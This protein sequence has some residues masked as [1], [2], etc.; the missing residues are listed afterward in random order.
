MVVTERHILTLAAKYKNANIADKGLHD[1]TLHE[2]RYTPNSFLTN[3]VTD[4]ST[5]LFRLISDVYSGV[6]VQSVL[7]SIQTQE[8]AGRS[9]SAQ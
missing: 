7:A 5:F 2:Y 3:I 9:E 6:R 8:V 4:I 1:M